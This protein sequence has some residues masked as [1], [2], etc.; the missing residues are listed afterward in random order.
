M[1][2]VS[3]AKLPFPILADSDR[4]LITQLGILHHGGGPG[5]ADI[6]MPALFL[7][8][9]GGRIVWQRVAHS[10]VDRPDPQLV[11]DAVRQAIK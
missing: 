1:R 9:R 4:K 5:G 8:D 3:A 2:V 6:A 7:V 11:L 10:V